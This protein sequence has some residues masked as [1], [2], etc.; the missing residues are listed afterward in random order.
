L[1][2]EETDLKPFESVIVAQVHDENKV[3]ALLKGLLD[4]V[5]NV[6]GIKHLPCSRVL[7][8]ESNNSFKVFAGDAY[9]F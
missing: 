9:T 5:D 2:Y 7:I 6:Q 1:L 3:K 8:D 4:L